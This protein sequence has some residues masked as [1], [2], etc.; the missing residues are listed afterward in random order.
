LVLSESLDAD[1]V[2][3]LVSVAIADIFPERCDEWLIANE[4]A[5]ATFKQELARR[6]DVALRDIARKE[7]SLRRV[8]RE[9]V[10]GDVMKHFPYELFDG[11]LGHA[12][13]IH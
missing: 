11:I 13:L 1:A 2:Q 10:V 9:A 4:N 3:T 5:H 8:L 12:L 6:K 7:D